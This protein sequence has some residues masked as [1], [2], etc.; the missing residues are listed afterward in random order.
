MYYVVTCHHTYK[1]KR[2]DSFLTVEEHLAA[3]EEA[4]LKPLVHT[5]SASFLV[6]SSC[7]EWSG[8]CSVYH[9][10]S[11]ETYVKWIYFA[12]TGTRAC[13]LEVSS[14]Q[15]GH[16]GEWLGFLVI[17]TRASG[18][19]RIRLLLPGYFTC[20]LL[21]PKGVGNVNELSYDFSLLNCKVTYLLITAAK[22]EHHLKSW[23]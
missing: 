5:G 18:K 21:V 22:N 11:L 17:H 7:R 8:L 23:D 19:E 6:A 9:L 13:A 10:D 16:L 14:A 15:S 20:S 12:M 2:I 3:P 1:W 4:I